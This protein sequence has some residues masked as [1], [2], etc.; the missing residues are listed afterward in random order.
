MPNPI[1]DEL[2]D[3]VKAELAAHFRELALRFPPRRHTV[4][5]NAVTMRQLFASRGW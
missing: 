4:P 2:S 5:A 1:T 3:E